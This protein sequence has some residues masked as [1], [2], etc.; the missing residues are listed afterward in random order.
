MSLN[1]EKVEALQL[2]PLDASY[3]VA[4]FRAPSAHLEGRSL[5]IDS[6]GETESKSRSRKGLAT[7]GIKPLTLLIT[8]LVAYPYLSFCYYVHFHTLDVG[9]L[10]HIGGNNQS[11]CE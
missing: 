8:P 10:A 9:V 4:R 2:L 7:N 3:S 6:Y 11:I 1:T 5:D